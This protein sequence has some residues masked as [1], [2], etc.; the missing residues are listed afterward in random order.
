MDLYHG[1]TPAF[2]T[3]EWTKLFKTSSNIAALLVRQF[4]GAI[5]EYGRT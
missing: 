4:V 1:L 5:E 3:K 2:L